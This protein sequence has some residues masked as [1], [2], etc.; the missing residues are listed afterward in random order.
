MM[1]QSR[2]ILII[3]GAGYIGSHTHHELVRRG[4]GVIVYDNLS[5]GFREAVHP[6]A[7]WWKAISRTRPA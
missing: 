3:G 2:T 6:A 4:Y 5:T 1:P 7:G